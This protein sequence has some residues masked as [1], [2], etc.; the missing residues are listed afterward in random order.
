MAIH[1]K[2]VNAFYLT[3]WIV[4]DTT[5]FISIIAWEKYV[6]TLKTRMTASA[7]LPA[8]HSLYILFKS[9]GNDGDGDRDR[10]DEDDIYA[11]L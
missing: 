4:R 5:D 10:D 1:T 9:T 8:L 6:P 11:D 3:T 2:T 7:R